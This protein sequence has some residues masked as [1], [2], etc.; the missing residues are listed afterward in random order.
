M[1]IPA[2]EEM[3]NNYITLPNEMKIIEDTITKVND[4]TGWTHERFCIL[5]VPV[6][7]NFNFTV[8][9]LEGSKWIG[10]GAVDK[11][12]TSLEAGKFWNSKNETSKNLV[13]QK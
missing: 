6:D 9:I 2:K 10:V 4:S 7:K 5:D 11:K 8:E 3:S 1:K 13:Y 12:L